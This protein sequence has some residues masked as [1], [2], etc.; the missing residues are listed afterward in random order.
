MRKNMPARW[1][2][3]AEAQRVL[4]EAWLNQMPTPSLSETARAALAVWLAQAPPAV[5]SA[6]SDSFAICVRF[7][8][9]AAGSANIPVEQ[10]TS[11]ELVV[12]V[13]T[14]TAL[15]LTVPRSI[16]ASAVEVV[17]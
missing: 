12:N 15:G 17:E 1:I 13:K 9:P 10:P 14:S 5:C 11:L 3:Q 4:M 2:E 16:L 7:A 8:K 6:L